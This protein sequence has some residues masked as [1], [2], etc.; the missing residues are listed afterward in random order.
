MRITS[1][2]RSGRWELR[3]SVDRWLEKAPGF[4]AARWGQRALPSALFPCAVFGG[5]EEDAGWGVEFQRECGEG[6]KPFIFLGFV[7]QRHLSA[8]GVAGVVEEEEVGF[9]VEFF[10]E[11]GR[12][13]CRE[14]GYM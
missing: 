11:I 6:W 3:S 2:R 12:A 9:A 13:S 5:F 10:G 1:I 14:R 4:G 8:R 7:V